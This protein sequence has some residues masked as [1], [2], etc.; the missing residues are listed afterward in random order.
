MTQKNAIFSFVVDVVF[1]AVH[2]FSYKRSMIKRENWE[3]GADLRSFYL[4]VCI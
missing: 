2:V 3:N 4:G 1:C